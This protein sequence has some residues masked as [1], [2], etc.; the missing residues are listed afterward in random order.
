MPQV[1]QQARPKLPI[2]NETNFHSG[3][4]SNIIAWPGVAKQHRRPSLQNS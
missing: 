4:L 2:E 3:M 1:D